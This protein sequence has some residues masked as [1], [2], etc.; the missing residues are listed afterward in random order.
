MAEDDDVVG[1]DRE[2]G[3]GV[4]DE[5]KWTRGWCTMYGG[6]NPILKQGTCVLSS[7][8]DGE[9]EGWPGTDVSSTSIVLRRLVPEES[10]A[11]IRPQT[12]GHR[13]EAHHQ[14]G[15]G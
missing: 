13:A 9:Y 10:D 15:D 6:P 5:C 14:F 11:A 1:L 12:T 2:G 3:A 7:G 8:D 4:R